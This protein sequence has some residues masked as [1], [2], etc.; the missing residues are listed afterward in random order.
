MHIAV[1]GA[2]SSSSAMWLVTTFC[3]SH[4]CMPCAWQDF[5]LRAKSSSSWVSSGVVKLTAPTD[6]QLLLF[7]CSQNT[8][9]HGTGHAGYG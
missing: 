1:E 5:A 2:R 7:C 4:L 3:H 8:V 9:L 6:T